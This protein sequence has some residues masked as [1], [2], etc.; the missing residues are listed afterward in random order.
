[1][2]FFNNLFG[3]KNRPTV[4][5]EQIVETPPDAIKNL[6]ARDKHRDPLYFYNF[7]ERIKP[8]AEWLLNGYIEA[9]NNNNKIGIKNWSKGLSEGLYNMPSIWYSMGEPIDVN[10]QRFYL[11]YIVYYQNCIN[12]DLLNGGYQSSSKILAIGILLNIDKDVFEKISE[13]YIEEGY[14]DFILDSLIHVQYPSH[15]I[16]ETLQ[17]PKETYIQ[18]LSAILR[19]TSKQ[20]AQAIIKDTLENHFYCKETL[21]AAYRRH[22]MEFHIGYWAWELAALVKILELDDDSIKDNP[23][24]PYDMVH[25]TTA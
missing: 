14:A 9:K 18:R 23:Y 10:W 16:A 7:L 21:Q 3:K 24:Y 13:R 19:S 11:K 25:W 2:G 12:K 17:F 4:E 22:K 15:P 20:E 8:T 1:M 6:T 5:D